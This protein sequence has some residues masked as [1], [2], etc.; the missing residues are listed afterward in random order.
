MRVTTL[1]VALSLAAIPSAALGQGGLNAAARN[2]YESGSRAFAE[3]RFAEAARAF[4]E[5][6]AISHAPALL[7]NLG[8]ALEASGDAAG[9]LDALSLF[10]DG[11]AAGFDRAALDQQIEALRARVAEERARPPAP[12]SPTP[13]AAAP[14]VI[15]RE[16]TMIQPAWYRV[17]YRRSTASTVVPWVLLGVGGALGILG[18]IQG[19]VAS[20][21]V[22]TLNAVNSGATPWSAS[23]Q[24]SLD[25]AGDAVGGAYLFSSLG[26]AMALSGALWLILRGPG[27]RV[28]INTA[29]ALTVAPF[30][31]GLMVGG[32]L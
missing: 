20:A 23:A 11:G 25:R 15:V 24:T 9:A 14:T 6:H 4:R 31:A 13:E 32:A 3:G 19:A 21:D 28:V 8:R 7:F 22:N 10:R 27:E 5:A 2:Y 16:R 18:A 17:E 1:L 26:G 29:P 12:A 30:G